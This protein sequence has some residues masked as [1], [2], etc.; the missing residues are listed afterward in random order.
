MFKEH[1]FSVMIYRGAH[2]PVPSTLRWRKAQPTVWP[3]VHT[4]PSRKR[5]FS[6]NFLKSEEFENAG[7]MFKCGR[8]TFWKRSIWKQWRH[9]NHVISLSE[10]SSSTN[11][12][13]PV[14]IAFLIS[15]G[16]VRTENIFKVSRVKPPFLNSFGVVWTRSWLISAHIVK[17]FTFPSDPIFHA[18]NF[19]EKKNSIWIKSDFSMKF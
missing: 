16:V 10:F 13:W 9:D 2:F 8:K 4:N 3:T 6:K 17:I 15:S 12:K 18:M 7:F 14:T 1:S 5:S 19:G 11:P